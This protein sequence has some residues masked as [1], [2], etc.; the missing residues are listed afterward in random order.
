[1]A[2]SIGDGGDDE[3]D[4]EGGERNWEGIGEAVKAQNWIFD[5]GFGDLER[6]RVEY[7]MGPEAPIAKGT[8]TWNPIVLRHNRHAAEELTGAD[9]GSK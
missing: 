7:D 2:A 1:M 6:P 4:W 5:G 9:K 8:S 3:S